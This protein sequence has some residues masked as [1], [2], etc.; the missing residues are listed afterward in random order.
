MSSIEIKSS[1]SL[2]ELLKG[3]EQLTIPASL[4]SRFGELDQKRKAETLSPEEHAELIALNDQIES[5]NVD[6]LTNLNML[7]EWKGLSL[8]AL[9]KELQ[10][11]PPVYD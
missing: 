9:M 4:R 8:K 6:R 2:G 1:V 3:V 10:I 7:A 11:V 5:L